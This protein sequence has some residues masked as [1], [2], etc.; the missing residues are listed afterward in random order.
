MRRVDTLFVV[1]HNFVKETVKCM[2]FGFHC[3]LNIFGYRFILEI[4]FPKLHTSFQREYHGICSSPCG[5]LWFF[6]ERTKGVVFDIW[7]EITADTA[8]VYV[9][10]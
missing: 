9:L 5:G 4:N 6:C 1:V 10:C 3:R 7:I 8:C 2:I